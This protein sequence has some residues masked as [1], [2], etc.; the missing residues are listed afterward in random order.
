MGSRTAGPAA[1]PDLFSSATPQETPSRPPKSAASS[2]TILPSDLPTAIKHLSDQ[3]LEQLVVAV[4]A[5]RQ[6]R[7]KKPTAL[8]KAPSKQVEAPTLTV[9]KL[10]A[11]RAAFKAGVTLARI[12]KQFGIP[13]AEVR[14]AIANDAIKR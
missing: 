10:N 2:R 14:K 1:T 11:V 13:Q 4:A 9:G 5:E 8:E 3:E 7:G 6:R 12:A